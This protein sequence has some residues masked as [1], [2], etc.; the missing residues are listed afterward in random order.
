MVSNSQVLGV[1]E[2]SQIIG[3]F[4]LMMIIVG[5]YILYYFLRYFGIS[6]RN[7]STSSSLK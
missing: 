2:E 1:I 3:L 5:I 4:V 6:I 7:V